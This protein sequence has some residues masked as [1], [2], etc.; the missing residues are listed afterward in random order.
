M[1]LQRRSNIHGAAESIEYPDSGR[2]QGSECLRSHKTG[3]EFM[4]PFLCYALSSGDSCSLL[5]IHGGVHDRFVMHGFQV[6][7][8]K[9]RCSAESLIDP[10]VEP[11][12]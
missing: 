3:Q 12:A 5:G 1:L 7:D 4:N 10:C 11:L 6:N 8:D 2:M 9:E